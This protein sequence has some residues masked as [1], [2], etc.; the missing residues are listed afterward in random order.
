LPRTPKTK[1]P[2]PKRK[3]LPPQVQQR[4]TRPVPRKAP[5]TPRTGFRG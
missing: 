1:V 4:M 3:P 5:P 2:A